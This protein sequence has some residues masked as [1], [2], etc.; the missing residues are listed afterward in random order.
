MVRVIT[1]LGKYHFNKG[2]KV[3]PH[4]HEKSEQISNIV[5]GRL[6]VVANGHEFVVSEGESY[7][8]PAG[9]E[10]WMEAL[11]DTDS[12]DVFAPPG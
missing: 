11:E 4:K 6:K 7:I 5:K 8:I 2:V 12:L 1:R 3:K 9:V 10:H